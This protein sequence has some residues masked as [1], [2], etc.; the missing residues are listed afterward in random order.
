[1]KRRNILK[2][3]LGYTLL[4]A[5]QCEHIIFMSWKKGERMCG[6]FFGSDSC[7]IRRTYTYTW[8]LAKPHVSHVCMREEGYCCIAITP[9]ANHSA[10]P[11]G[12]LF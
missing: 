3:K 11:E 7:N 9:L 2:Q 5:P 12:N 1:M 8:T 4:Y 6:K 10:K